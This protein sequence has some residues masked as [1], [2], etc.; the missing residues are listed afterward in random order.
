M[1]NWRVLGVVAGL[2]ALVGVLAG[3]GAASDPPGVVVMSGLDNPRGLAFGPEGGL[4]VAEAGRGG[5]GPP[6]AMIRGQLQCVGATGAVSRLWHG[7]QERIATGLPSMRRRTAP[8]DRAARHLAARARRRL[9][10]DRARREPGHP[11]GVRARLRP[12]RS[13]EAE[14]NWLA[15]DDIS[16]YEAEHNPDESPVPDSNPYGVLAEPGGRIVTDAGGNDLLRV[17]SNGDISTLAVFPSRPQGRETDSV[18]TSVAV[19]PDGAYYVGELTGAPFFADIARVYRVV[20]GQDPEPYGPTFSFIIDLAWGPDG[21]LY[22][23]QH[24]SEDGLAGPGQLFRVE[25]DGTKTLVINDLEAPASLLFSA[26]ALYVS[27]R[28]ESAGT[29]EVLR[30]DLP[31]P[32]PPPPPPPRPHHLHLRPPPPPRHLHHLRLH[33][34]SATATPPPP[35]PPPP[36]PTSS[37]A[38]PSDLSR[39]EGHRND[40]GGG[41]SR[42]RKE[43]LHGRACAQR[44]FNQAARRQGDR[45]AAEGRS[46]APDRHPHQHG[47]RPALAGGLG[48]E[49]PERPV[50]AL[51]G[52]RP[53][54][55]SVR[56]VRRSLTR[57]PSSS[58]IGPTTGDM[59]NVRCQARTWSWIFRAG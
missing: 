45:P 36:P 23:L 34:L 15:D 18:P 19:G 9:R 55:R 28:G 21:N 20:P 16:S 42:N 38:S 39:A 11:S 14:W 10:D 30:F 53:I 47:R 4:Y 6:C 27:N 22:V 37:T 31:L 52:A 41:S 58:A 40:A 43:H 2:V 33:H 24:G 26:D 49:N 46:A 3:S 17:R 1:R 44:A 13:L 54:P 7:A 50:A 56:L 25:S 5:P 29:G 35:P 12:A 59:P 8:G 51:D 48:L 57:S 32:P